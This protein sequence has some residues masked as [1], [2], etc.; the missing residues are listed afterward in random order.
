[1]ICFWRN[2]NRYSKYDDIVEIILSFLENGYVFFFS[3]TGQAARSRPS[4][5]RKK[6]IKYSI[7]AWF[8]PAVIVIIS[9]ALDKTN[10]I[11]I[12][13]GKYHTLFVSSLPK[14]FH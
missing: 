13:Y 9:V 8:T 11:M 5:C 6:L 12:G 10:T 14:S 1:M 4:D 2:S 3:G 7:F